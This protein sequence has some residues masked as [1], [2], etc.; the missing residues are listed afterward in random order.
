MSA[1]EIAKGLTKAQREAL[2]KAGWRFSYLEPGPRS[3]LFMKT[4]GANFAAIWLWRFQFA[5][6]M[7]WLERPARQLHPEVFTQEQSNGE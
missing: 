4:R 3:P 2:P 5:W 7:P 1:R 6:P